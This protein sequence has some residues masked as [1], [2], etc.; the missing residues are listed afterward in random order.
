MLPV[1][2][3]VLESINASSH[4]TTSSKLQLLRPQ[5]LFLP[6]FSFHLVLFYNILFFKLCNLISIRRTESRGDMQRFS[7][8]ILLAVA[9]SASTGGI[10]YVVLGKG[11]KRREGSIG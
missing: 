2:R 3:A 4:E 1:A 11:R 5:Y 9:Y 7:T 10:A 6:S 8:A